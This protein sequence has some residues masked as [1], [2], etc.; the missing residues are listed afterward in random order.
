M[1][2][3]KVIKRTAL[4]KRCEQET[5]VLYTAKLVEKYGDGLEM[6]FI[7][8]QVVL[9]EYF[10]TYQSILTAFKDEHKMGG[11]LINHAKIA[12][13]SILAFQRLGAKRFFA[14]Y[15]NGK[16][17]DDNPYVARAFADFVYRYTCYYLRVDP[18]QL[19]KLVRRDFHI[20][21]V[22]KWEIGPEWGS[23]GKLVL[24]TLIGEISPKEVEC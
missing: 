15:Q 24:G 2:D 5:S 11:D 21:I 3:L 13:L 6:R 14:L 20:C 22:R 10:H 12:A 17:N 8:G 9:D 4:I 23:W 19:D 16:K 1:D 18:K 7:G